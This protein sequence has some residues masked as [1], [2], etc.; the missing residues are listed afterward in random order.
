MEK[1]RL[2]KLVS[3]RTGKF[4]AWAVTNKSNIT[5]L[6]EEQEEQYKNSLLLANLYREFNGD[7]SHLAESATFDYTEEGSFFGLTEEDRN[8]ALVKKT[9]LYG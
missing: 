3:K 7:Y 5:N 8:R 2:V 4:K 9:N 6:T 1:Q